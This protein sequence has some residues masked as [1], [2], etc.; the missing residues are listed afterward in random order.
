[1]SLESVEFAPYS[2]L[3][4]LFLRNLPLGAAGKLELSRNCNWT[5]KHYNKWLIAQAKQSLKMGI[6]EGM[7]HCENVFAFLRTE[8]NPNIF[9]L[10]CI[11][12]YS[13]SS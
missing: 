10:C 5:P 6:S 12:K 3:Q 1:M 7:L 9:L 8:D 11:L 4:S 2:K 13:S